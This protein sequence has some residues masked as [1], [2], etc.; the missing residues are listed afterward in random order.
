MGVLNIFS[1]LRYCCGRVELVKVVKSTFFVVVV[2]VLV[3]VV[4]RTFDDLYLSR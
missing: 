4:T 3:H 1:C 2:V